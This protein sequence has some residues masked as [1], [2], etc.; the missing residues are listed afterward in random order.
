MMTNCRTSLGPSRPGARAVRL[1][2]LLWL[3]AG[4][5]GCSGLLD[6]DNPNSVPIEEISNPAA[7]KS[8]ANGVHASLGR[9]WNDG[10]TL[11]SVAS[12][13]LRW[14]GSRDAW[15]TLD[16]GSISEPTNE[17][18]DA[19]FPYL[20][21][22]RWLADTAIR[23]LEKFRADH[24]LPDTNDLARV[25][26]FGALIYTALGNFFED[27]PLASSMRR[28]A[29]PVGPDAM[30]QT[31]DSAIAY[32]IR[33][34]AALQ[35]LKPADRIAD[36]E[37]ALTTA[38]AWARYSKAA[39]ALLPHPAV[40]GPPPPN[41]LVNDAGA[42]TDAQAAIAMAT[43]LGK[44]DWTYGFHYSAAT[45]L[46]NTEIMIGF[47]VNERL[48]NR[49]GDAYIIPDVENNKKVGSVRLL[50]PIAGTP[51]PVLSSIIFGTFGEGKF[52]GLDGKTPHNRYAAV[53]VLSVRELHLIIAEA[54]LAAA[55][56]SGF[57]TEINAVRA[58]NTGLPSYDP[59]N[60]NHPTPLAM[61]QHERRVNL[62]IQ[63][64]RLWDHYRFGVPSEQW[65]AGSEAITKPGILLPITITELQSNPCIV[66]PGSC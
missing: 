29:P 37:L 23:Q 4:L 34:I 24:T 33:G 13:E 3:P 38:R 55:D 11:L 59:S 27:F 31:F 35:T 18:V 17:F 54:R 64:R 51:D 1:A 14:V 25:Y 7:A 47:T 21:E 32:T 36:L 41:P 49:V 45:A 20:G 53:P 43:T 19:A 66:S 8:L 50:D 52:G 30:T 46:F 60:P 56:T 15:N 42:I 22:A 9:A 62:F 28:A 2:A 48:E 65:V 5:A 57:T 10:I 58:L 39:W 44:P 6:V 26:L 12:D 63:G 40:A 61:L 16:R